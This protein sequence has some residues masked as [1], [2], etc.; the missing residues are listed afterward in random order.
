MEHF[1]SFES[2]L[3]KL[4]EEKARQELLDT[5][6][7]LPSEDPP[8]VESVRLMNSSKYELGEGGN[9]E[10]IV[11]MSEP[12]IVTGEPTLEIQFH[13]GMT[14]DAKY[15]SGS[16]STEL[17]FRYT[18]KEDDNS[19]GVTISGKTVMV[20]SGSTIKS[21]K[22]LDA[23]LRLPQAIL[24][25][26]PLQVTDEFDEIIV[27]ELVTTLSD[28]NVATLVV[29]GR[30]DMTI[31]RWI[32]DLLNTRYSDRHNI[33]AL[34]AQ[35]SSNLLEI[36]KRRDEF[37]SQIPV[38]FMADLDELVLEDPA[39]VLGKYPDIIWTT[40][41]SIEN[42]LYTDGDP[43]SLIPNS[44]IQMYND[45]LNNAID[46]FVENV[47]NWANDL[48]VGTDIDQLKKRYHAAISANVALKLR[49]KDLFDV[50][51]N[52][53]EKPKKHLPLCDLVISTVRSHSPLMNR[54]ILE[55][56][57]EINIQLKKL[58]PDRQESIITVSA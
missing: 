46:N 31:F 47:A 20:P 9:I 14:N 13:P 41:Y 57:N 26:L 55:I 23:E 34:Q 35:G 12:V 25:D 16:G 8:K 5:P 15:Q 24:P 32:E 38:A 48:G 6:S 42:D 49:G 21:A 43:I 36:Y 39:N 7:S 51:N 2:L 11:E 18:V 45:M 56:S 29:E 52:T 30:D 33:D 4:E 54:L 58:P 3:S 22:D 44:K 37:S 50:L 19:R 28:S 53:R 1:N 17:L 40:G 10:V 27:R